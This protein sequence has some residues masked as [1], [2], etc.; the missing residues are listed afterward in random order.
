[1]PCPIRHG[2]EGQTAKEAVMSDLIVRFAVGAA[3]FSIA[4]LLVVSQ[5]RREHLRERI[6][7]PTNQRHRWDWMRRRRQGHGS[8]LCRRGQAAILW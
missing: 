5:Y 8:A 6:V 4:V 7:G 1:M 2:P 3:A